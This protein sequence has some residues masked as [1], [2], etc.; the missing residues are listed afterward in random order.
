MSTHAFVSLRDIMRVIH[1]IQF[2]FAARKV[3]HPGCARP[4]KTHVFRQCQ[5]WLVWPNGDA[6]RKNVGVFDT[7]RGALCVERQHWVSR[8]TQQ[9]R[10]PRTPIWKW[11]AIVKRRPEFCGGRLDHCMYYGLSARIVRQ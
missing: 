3:L 7:L 8:I 9:H 10:P 6:T 5:G 1:L 4:A 11:L 2:F